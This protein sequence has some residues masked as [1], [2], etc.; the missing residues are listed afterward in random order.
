MNLLPTVL[1]AALELNHVAAASIVLLECD[2]A[3]LV[4][5][6]L[7]LEVAVLIGALAL[8][9]LAL[10]TELFECHWALAAIMLSVEATPDGSL[11]NLGLTLGD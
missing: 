2:T 1:Q 8:D 5:L 7:D 11:L 6:A 4:Y 9:L 10:D 3:I